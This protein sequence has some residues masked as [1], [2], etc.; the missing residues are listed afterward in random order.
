M[1]T[2]VIITQ[3]DGFWDV[4]NF[5]HKKNIYFIRKNKVN[6]WKIAIEELENDETIYHKIQLNAKLLIEQKF[7]TEEFGK[8]LFNIVGK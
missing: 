4:E 5:E 3:T 8:N 6:D 7:N 1:K 2:P